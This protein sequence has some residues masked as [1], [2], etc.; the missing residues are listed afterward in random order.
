MWVKNLA[1]SPLPI[2]QP[3]LDKRTGSPLPVPNPPLPVG[4]YVGLFNGFLSVQL[5][6]GLGASGY[7]NYISSLP[8]PNDGQWYFV[9]VSVQRNNPSGLV[10][11]VGEKPQVLNSE[12]FNPT[13]RL[14]DLNNTADLWIGGHHGISL[15]APPFDGLMD[16]IEL[17]N[18]ALTP[19]E[20]EAIFR[21]NIGGKCKC[22]PLPD[23]SG[24]TNVGCDCFGECINGSYCDT[25][26]CCCIEDPG[27]CYAPNHQASIKLCEIGRA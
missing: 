15:T 18:R 19:T 1:T 8:V 22:E 12:I 25:P 9:G 26:D 5:A 17:F 2:N 24:C 3:L 13:G 20:V 16:E 27:H 4:Y 10:M 21:A 6:D 14:G 7:T 23:G 11:Y